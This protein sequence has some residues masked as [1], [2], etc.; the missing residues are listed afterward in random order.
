MF[1]KKESKFKRLLQIINILSEHEDG[2]SQADLA[3]QVGTSRANVYKDLAIIEEKTG[4]L[5]SEDDDGRLYLFKKAR[6]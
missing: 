4:S 1:G 5:L 2:V 3:R 6:R